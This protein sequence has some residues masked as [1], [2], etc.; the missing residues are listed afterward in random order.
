[1]RRTASWLLGFFW[2]V[3]RNAVK[4]ASDDGYATLIRPHKEK[5]LHT[6]KGLMFMVCKFYLNKAVIK[7]LIL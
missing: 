4:I 5:R 2:G 6:F 7:M 1:M 3:I